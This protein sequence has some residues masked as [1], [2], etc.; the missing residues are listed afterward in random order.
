MKVPSF[1]RDE[2]LRSMPGPTQE[3]VD[4][5]ARFAQKAGARVFLVGGPVRDLLIGRPIHD[6]DLLVEASKGAA[7]AAMTT[8]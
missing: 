7:V 6:V 8:W 4:R 5:V 2:V 3:L 1:T